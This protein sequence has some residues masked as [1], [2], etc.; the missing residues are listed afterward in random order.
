MGSTSQSQHSRAGLAAKRV[1]KK[2]EH[3]PA[4]Y[5]DLPVSSAAKHRNSLSHVQNDDP[6]SKICSTFCEQTQLISVQKTKQYTCV[7][8][9]P[10]SP[11]L[12]GRSTVLDSLDEV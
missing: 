1:R 10:T 12:E 11:V 3:E 2:T 8:T 9:A 5:V 6:E 4:P 7:T